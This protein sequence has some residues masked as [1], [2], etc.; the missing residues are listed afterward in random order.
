MK[1]VKILG[2]VALTSLILAACGDT[3][4]SETT[5]KET[6]QSTAVSSEKKAESSV[7]EE[8]PKDT[9]NFVEK[10]S[11]ATFDG[12]ILKG[13]SYSIKITDHKVI[14]PGD[15]GNEYGEKPV[16]AFWFDTLVSPNYDNST[17]INPNTAWILNFEA[18]QDNSSDMVNKLEVAPLPD[19][20]HLQSQSAEIKPGG[21]VASS[22]AYT[23]TDN[24]TPVKLTAKSMLGNDFGSAEFHVK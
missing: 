2:L 22:I 11:D 3:S 19:E 16:I 13:N 24:K 7:K 17:P 5:S 1:K 4:S 9:G 20:A 12:K 14:Q 10:A 15:K 6:N 8:A 18:V 21:T 23:L